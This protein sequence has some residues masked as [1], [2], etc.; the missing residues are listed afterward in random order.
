MK[1]NP[2]LDGIRALA[3]L[4]VIAFH[5]HVPGAWFG[6]Y[7]VDVFFVLSGFLITT[8]LRQE[9]EAGGIR[10]GAFY[11]RRLRRLYPALLLMLALYLLTFPLLGVPGHHIEDAAVAAT[12]LMDYLPLVLGHPV[13]IGHT[14]S[15]SVEEHFYLLWPLAVAGLTLLRSRK[16]V[17]YVLAVTYGLATI[18]R[19]WAEDYW[20]YLAMWMRFDTRISGLMFGALLAYLP[21]LRSR[22]WVLAVA[23][24]FWLL[25]RSHDALMMVPMTPAEWLAGALVLWAA[26]GSALP[27]AWRPLAWL[28]RISYGLYLFHYPI[29]CYL[30]LG[31][32][33]WWQALAITLALSLPLAH[34][35]Y[36]YWE[37][38]FRS[39][40][41]VEL[42]Q[43]HADQPDGDLAQ[44]LDGSD[45]L[46]VGG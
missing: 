6:R 15:L 37:S 41:P 7:G 44:Q 18:Y 30:A 12:Y 16:A 8:L 24:L 10:F 14:W 28:G 17:V 9:A 26:S 27:L 23:P 38:R 36:V 34:L 1:Y 4:G 33:P 25:L 39:V 40:G 22:Y 46:R 35:S 13:I 3:V 45:R 19:M 29:A 42:P 11:L 2:A 31:D 5:C 20:G 32:G 21:E 43:P